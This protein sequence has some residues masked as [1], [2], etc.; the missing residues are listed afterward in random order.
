VER[1]IKPN[2]ALWEETGEFP[3][4][5]IK[6]LGKLGYLT[7]FVPEEYGG[8]GLGREATAIILEEF[9]RGCMA[10]AG[11]LAVT[12]M[13]AGLIATFGSEAQKQK[14]LPRMAEGELLGAFALTEPNAGS[15]ALALESKAVKSTEGFRL[16]GTKIFISGGG[17]ADIYLVFARLI[18]EGKDYGITCFIVEKGQQ[19][20][21]FGKKEKKLGLNALPARELIF[22]DVPVSEENILGQIGKGFNYAMYALDGGRINIGAIATGVAQAAFEEAFQYAQIRKQFN[23]PLI[24]FQAIAFML[25][26]MYI[27]IEA[28]RLMVIQAART[29]DEKGQA[30]LEA[31]AAKTFATDMAVKV[32]TDAVQILGGYGYTKEFNVER[33]FRQAKLGQ[34]VEG[35]NQIQRLV[36]A[37]EL[38]KRWGGGK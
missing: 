28:A 8:S 21:S 22:E 20:F 6:K 15:D 27:N 10:T 5:L 9:A 23:E 2:A 18:S 16:S 7:L 19:G 24:N 37:R 26:D 12:N 36:I 25:A 34:I 17:E 38:V 14:Y 30:T 11:Y 4:E 29:W 32:T 3:L 1:E 13:V 33:Y 35:T 31:A